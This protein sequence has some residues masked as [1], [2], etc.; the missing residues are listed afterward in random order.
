MTGSGEVIQSDDPVVRGL[1]VYVVGGAVRDSLLGQAAGDRDWVV[2][3]ASPEEMTARGFI[4]VGGDFPV[5]LHPSSKEEYALARTERKAGRGYKGFTFYTGS[6]VSLEDDLLRRDLTVNAIAQR[7]DGTLVDP[8]GGVDDLKARVLR[9]VGSAFSEDPVRLLR[10][11]RFAARF[12]EFSIAPETLALARE[13][14]DSGEV[15]ALVA[16]RVW[17][18][19]AKG[20]MTPQP[21]RMIEVLIETG[22]L[23]RVIPELVFDP[24]ISAELERASQ[25]DLPLASRYAILCRKSPRAEALG[26]ALRAPS[27]CIDRSVLLP[28]VIRA[29]AIDDSEAVLALLERCDVL[30]KPYRFI[31]LLHA[32][33]CVCDIDV[34]LWQARMEV[35]RGVDAGAVARACSDK[36]RIREAVRDARL[37]ALRRAFG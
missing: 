31:E 8:C 18:E 9:H 4:P 13:L 22:A 3:G 19:I 15:D 28:E 37:E 16:E 7:S 17:L 25:C 29:H 23:E 35:V 34:N 36:T 6:D 21:G 30:R 20:L 10:L 27:D 2:V 32:A 33:R 14:V 26:K 11:A 24:D 1:Q 5:F 12:P